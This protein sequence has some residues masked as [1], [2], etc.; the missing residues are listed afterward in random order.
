M[1]QRGVFYVRTDEAMAC[2]RM[3]GISKAAAA[4][5][6]AYNSESGIGSGQSR[7]HV[8]RS[9]DHSCSPSLPLKSCIIRRRLSN[10]PDAESH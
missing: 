7:M 2:G 10:S 9:V 1:D 5:L 4:V 3:D 8:K 6:S